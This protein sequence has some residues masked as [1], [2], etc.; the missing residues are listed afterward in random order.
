MSI[1]STIAVVDSFQ[2]LTTDVQST[3]G[4]P[5]E[6]SLP[7]VQCLLDRL[8]PL[9]HLVGCHRFGHDPQ[10]IVDVRFPL[11]AQRGHMID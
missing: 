9:A 1:A 6:P 7:S 10:E 8:P 4:S 3:F 11:V 2:P 5:S